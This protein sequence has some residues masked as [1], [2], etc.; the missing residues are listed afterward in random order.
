MHHPQERFSAV[1]IPTS[2]LRELTG[3][4]EGSRE[5]EG[6]RGREEE[7]GA[8]CAPPPSG[9][10]G[11]AARRQ[12]RR[13][14]HG[15]ASSTASSAPAEAGI[16][17]RLIG[18]LPAQTRTC[19]VSVIWVHCRRGHTSQPPLGPPRSLSRAPWLCLCPPGSGSSC[20]C[21]CDSRSRLLS[22][23]G[24][25]A[26]RR[27]LRA[28]GR[29]RRRGETSPNFGFWGEPVDARNGPGLRWVAND[30]TNLWSG[31][32]GGWGGVGAGVCRCLGKRLVGFGAT[33]EKQSEAGLGVVLQTSARTKFGYLRAF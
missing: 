24:C 28:Q 25:T 15:A 26:R 27:R 6:C 29:L 12:R 18:P 7:G 2:A 31:P 11:G 3:S 9:P 22:S 30:E 1:V 17:S 8:A 19:R 33:E 21:G 23:V 4:P 14:A 5:K 10:A 20:G 32:S 16:C 13:R